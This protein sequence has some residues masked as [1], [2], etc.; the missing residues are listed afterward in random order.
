M[1][2][3]FTSALLVLSTATIQ[4]ADAADEVDTVRAAIAKHSPDLAPER[5]QAS[6]ALGLYHVVLGGTSGYITKD[7]R[8]FIPGDLLDVVSRKNLTEDIRKTERIALLKTVRPEDEIVF[9]PKQRKH[10]ITVFTDV[11]CG[12][13]RKLHSEIAKY[14]EAGIA[15]QYVA[16]PRSGPGTESW[17][18]ME[19]VWCSA[20]RGEQLTRAK[21]GES[22][23][24]KPA[25]CKS[26]PIE[27]HYQL[28]ERI[29]VQGTP[30][31]ILEDG[32]LI[33]GYI[34][35]AELSEQLAKIPA[36]TT[37]LRDAH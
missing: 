25:A 12:F 27:A 7:G 11:D 19:D 22:I 31:I 33:G 18:K 4:L 30:T 13:C 10:S 35:A 8:Y 1:K 20:D 23:A 17:T 2:T 34:P 32:S 9:A 26:T 16:F 21:L 15:V 24:Q 3:V 6:P 5:L 37:A 28:G 36:A 14:V 29:G